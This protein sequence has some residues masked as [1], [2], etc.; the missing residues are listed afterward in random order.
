[1]NDLGPYEWMR[2]VMGDEDAEDV[3][4]ELSCG[5]SAAGRASAATASYQAREYWAG[6]FAVANRPALASCAMLFD[7]HPWLTPDL[8][9]RAINSLR[10]RT[11]ISP[12]DVV[13]AARHL[14]RE[15]DPVTPV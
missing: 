5:G 8:A 9:E 3:Y 13:V 12:E 14:A 2:D 10:D 15:N 7:E 1:M 6:F 4:A 11:A